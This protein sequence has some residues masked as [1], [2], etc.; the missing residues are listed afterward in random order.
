MKSDDELF[1]C[2]GKLSQTTGKSIFFNSVLRL[3]PKETTKTQLL[4]S[5]GDRR[6]P[7]TKGQWR[8]KHY[9]IKSS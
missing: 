1:H 3:I 5:T 9:Q 2:M 4:A 8:G 7:L 6:I